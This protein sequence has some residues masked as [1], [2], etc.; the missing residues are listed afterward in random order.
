MNFFKRFGL[1]VY[2]NVGKKEIRRTNG[3]PGEWVC[4]GRGWGATV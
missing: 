2:G 3:E 1:E 4:G